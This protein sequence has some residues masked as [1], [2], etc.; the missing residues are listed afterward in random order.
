LPLSSSSHCDEPIHG[1]QNRQ[2][3]TLWLL[4]A[5]GFVLER[6]AVPVKAIVRSN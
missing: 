3:V 2:E 6:E 5:F 1:R 4:R